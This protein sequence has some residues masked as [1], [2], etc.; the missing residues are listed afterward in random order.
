MNEQLY[1]TLLNVLSNQGAN[2]E[3]LQAEL[4]NKILAQS[5]NNPR[6]QLLSKLLNLQQSQ[7]EQSVPGDET[8]YDPEEKDEMDFAQHDRSPTYESLLHENQELYADL[9]SIYEFVDMLADALGACNACW[10]TYESCPHCNGNGKPGFYQMNRKLF[11]EWVFPAIKQM[12][13]K[14]KLN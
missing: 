8:I 1:E 12:K 9:E 6:M 11:N 7:A 13:K 4:Q 3:V 2:T 14:R 10:G 5:A